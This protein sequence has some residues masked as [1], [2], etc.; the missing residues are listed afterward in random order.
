M[1]KLNLKGL[2]N[3]HYTHFAIDFY[4]HSTYNIIIRR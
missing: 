4:A 3:A 2:K 1:D